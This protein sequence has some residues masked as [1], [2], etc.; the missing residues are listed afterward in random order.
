MVLT[1]SMLMIALAGGLAFLVYISLA[2]L[3]RVEE[4]KF[5][6]KGKWALVQ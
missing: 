4:I 6:A 1:S 5:N 2:I 3:D